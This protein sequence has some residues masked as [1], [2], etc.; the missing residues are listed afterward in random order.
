MKKEPI[1]AK[2]HIDMTNLTSHST[3]LLQGTAY[4]T[5]HDHLT[6][7]LSPHHLSIP[8]WKFLG[9]LHDHGKMRLADLA[10][11]LSYDPPQVT[12]LAKALEKKKLVKRVQDT[13]DERAKIISITPLGNTLITSIDPEVKKMLAVLMR[14]I[15][16]EELRVYIKVLATIVDNATEISA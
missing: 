3:G 1:L 4:N 14:G 13:K 2:L 9:Q 16:P 11:F 5:L 8:E 15:T 7:T 10:D 6:R 12:K